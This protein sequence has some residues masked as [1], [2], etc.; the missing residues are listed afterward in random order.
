MREGTGALEGGTFGKYEVVSWLGRGGMAEAFRCRLGGI[1][2]FEKDVVIKRIHPERAQDPDFLRMFL[3]EARLAAGLN[4]PN[5]AQ[6]FEVGEVS[7]APYIAMEYVAGPTL[8]SLIREAQKNDRVHY[9][10]FARVLAGVCEGLAYAHRACARD[11]TPLHI[12]HRD[13]TP[14]NIIVSFQGPP[15]L[16]DF[17]IAKAKGRVSNTEA[18]TLKGKLRYMAPEQ[19]TR[20]EIDHRADIF[21]LGVCLCEATTGHNPFGGAELNDVAVF[22]NILHGTLTRPSELAPDFPDELEDIILRA[23]SP[24]PDTRY[25]S[26]QD[27]GEDLL[28]FA[29]RAPHVSSA[30]AVSEWL[31]ELFPGQELT[32]SAQ[33]ARRQGSRANASTLAIPGAPFLGEKDL[34]TPDVLPPVFADA[35]ATPS[36]Q[37]GRKQT[38]YAVPVL[39]ACAL[40]MLGAFALRTQ[41]SHVSAATPRPVPAQLPVLVAG[42]ELSEEAAARAYLDEAERMLSFKAYA[43]ARE[44][45]EQVRELHVREPALNIRLARLSASLE[46]AVKLLRA[47]QALATGRLRD[48][49]DVAREVLE[50]EPQNAEALAIIARA[51]PARK[52]AADT[53]E[54]LSTA[55]AEPAATAPASPVPSAPVAAAPVAPAEASTPAPAEAA[56]STPVAPPASKPAKGALTTSE[57]PSAT[58]AIALKSDG[59]IPVPHLPRV[60]TVASDAELARVFSAVEGQV[61]TRAG[62][63][64]DFARG[65]TAALRRVLP[66]GERHELYPVAMYYFLVREAALGHTRLEASQ[67]LARAQGNQELLLLRDLPAKL[68]RL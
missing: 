62:I 67:N 1:G 2:G 25:Q 64:P 31:S 35:G 26:A 42:D 45:L 21:S 36:A 40:L 18:G 22:T 10:H 20:P 49:L 46:V 11:G 9:G 19:M 54:T 34:T 44:L 24:N 38:G 12:V 52:N 63:A 57:R 61:I 6:I 37:R 8:Q 47:Q 13:V 39:V 48:A 65:I 43:A 16:V 14:H 23:I 33:L 60:Q 55:R 32:L 29:S 66:D 53:H 28:E 51:Q 27:L 4:H 15:K 5:I 56:A 41:K 59:T 3:D 7:G 30:D 50:L 17:G 58:S 68:V